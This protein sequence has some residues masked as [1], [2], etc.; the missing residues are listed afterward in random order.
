MAWLSGSFACVPL[1][2]LAIAGSLPIA[3]AALAQYEVVETFAVLAGSTVTNTG[4]SVIS[5]N[6]GV[7][8]GT[9]ITGFP[10]GIVTPPFTFH[11]NDAVAVLAQS[12]L[13]SLYNVLQGQTPDQ[14]LTGQDLGGLTLNPGVYSFDQGAGLNGTLTLDGLGD[15][16]AIFIFVIDEALTTGSNSTVALQNMAQGGNVFFVVGSSATLGTST[17]FAGQIVALTSITLNTSA[18]INCGAALARNGAVTLDSN[19]IGICVL[20]AGTFGDG[21]EDEDTTDNAQAIADALD[22]YVAGGGVLPPGFAILAATLSPT[23]LADAL[24][25]LSGEVATGVSPTIGQATDSF[26]TLVSGGRGGGGVSVARLGDTGPSRGTVSVMGY[27]PDAGN[28]AFDS[29]DPGAAPYAP[30]WEAW[31]AGFGGV[32]LVDADAESGA[33][34]RTAN[35]YGVAF[36]IDHLTA[37]TRFGF[38]LATGGTD[39]QVGDGMGSGRTDAL[40]AAIHARAD[41]ETGYVSGALAYGSHQV[42]TVRTVDF[43]GI[44]RLTAD[45]DAQAL[46][47]QIEAGYRLGVLT[48]YA[49]ARAQAVATPAYAEVSEFGTASYALAFDEAV[50]ISLRS[51]I[52]A[53]LEWSTALDD[54]AVVTFDARAAWV[55]EFETDASLTARF[56]AVP[57]VA[58]ELDGARA[59]ADSAVVS[60]GARVRSAQGV[61]LAAAIEGAFAANAQSYGGSLTLGYAW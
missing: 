45:F 52:G 47:G 48:P 11:A 17:T 43:A 50:A 39:F 37:D 36:G 4:T 7:S 27:W 19:T 13:T 35:D 24:A 22:D 56:I 14:D 32:T 46:A 18:T 28:G 6:V 40:Q 5:G 25:Q 53:R 57:G 51:E 31:M 41:F 8:A 26:L 15:P 61:I 2:V 3:T 20:D 12:Q 44:D 34:G 59:G 10:P 23:E 16:N 1:S 38:A 42:E 54:G 49:A 33:A 9:A 58:F 21:L 30:R 55:H 60:A 29:F